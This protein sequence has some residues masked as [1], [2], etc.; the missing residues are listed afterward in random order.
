M[1]EDESRI[2]RK[3]PREVLDVTDGAV[4]R[5]EDEAET[6]R[7]RQ[8]SEGID[9][10]LRTLCSPVAARNDMMENQ[11][12]IQVP[13]IESENVSQQVFDTL[14]EKFPRRSKKIHRNNSSGDQI[15]LMNVRDSRVVERLRSLFKQE[16]DRMIRSIVRTNRERIVLFEKNESAR[17]R[18]EQE[19]K[20]RDRERSTTYEDSSFETEM[21]LFPRQNVN[22]AVVFPQK[23]KIEDD[24]TSIFFCDGC[25]GSYNDDPRR[26][27]DHV[28]V[29]PRYR[30]KTKARKKGTDDDADYDICS[31]MY[32]KIL[33]D[34]EKSRY[35][36]IDTPPLRL[37]KLPDGKSF[38]IEHVRVKVQKKKRAKPQT[39]TLVCPILAPVDFV[40]RATSWV[41]VGRNVRADCLGEMYLRMLLVV[42]VVKANFLA[43]FDIFLREY[44]DVMIA[45]GHF[46][47]RDAV[48]CVGMICKLDLA[49]F[50][51]RVDHH[52]LIEI[53]E[54][55]QIDLVVY[56]TS[57]VCLVLR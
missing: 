15:N 19:R 40:P 6:K 21:R 43:D 14:R 26:A 23:E 32:E 55:A 11:F 46:D 54:K 22:S 27:K 20:S 44:C 2:E 10:R 17:I 4:R 16:E 12:I 56:L 30:L 3:R 48:R 47:L 51:R 29:G 9:M 31:F 39:E 49:T 35:K 37:S 36:K 50:P 52:M 34:T 38:P 45:P 8:D 25:D 7:L 5:S 53:E 57:T 28:I 42:T 13:L 1:D 18:G 33:D 41:N 24:D